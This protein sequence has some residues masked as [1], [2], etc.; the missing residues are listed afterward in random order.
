MIGR[1]IRE[2]RL[3]AGMTQECLAELA[4]LHWKT[5]SYIE[6]GKHPFS[7]VTFVRLVQYLKTSPSRLLEG[8]DQLDE[9]RLKR[10]T[11]ALARKRQPKRS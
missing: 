1:N 4:N 8:S 6:R 11:K 2:A 10:V 3:R 9:K 7:I 5:L